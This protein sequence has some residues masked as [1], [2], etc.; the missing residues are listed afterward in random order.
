MLKV[1]ITLDKQKV[2]I[3]VLIAILFLL[4]QYVLLEK[5]VDVRLEEKIK[6]YEDGYEQGLIDAVVTIFQN[7]EDCKTTSLTIGNLTKHVFD[8]TCLDNDSKKILP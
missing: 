6:F 7:T 8:I 3:I 1:I 2:I 4:V 5:L